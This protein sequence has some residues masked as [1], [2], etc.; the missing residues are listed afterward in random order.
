MSYEYV[1]LASLVVLVGAA[2]QSTAGFGFS[3]IAGP[4][5]FAIEPA[6]V[7]GPVLVALLALTAL[8]S[9]RDGSF[10][11]RIGLRWAL[12]G[13]LPGT[14][15]GVALLQALSTRTLGLLSGAI[16]L[17]SVAL[18]VSPIAIKRSAGPVTFAGFLSGMSETTSSIGGPPVAL[19]YRRDAPGVLRG[20]MSL[21]FL[22]GV[23][24]SLV[25]LAAVGNFGE[26][27]ASAS[28]ALLPGTVAGFLLSKP[29]TSVFDRHAASVVLVLS[30]A[31]GLAVIGQQLV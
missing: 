6:L 17:V 5:L 26:E 29:L 22:V 10:R 14:V 7:P 3:L 8:S 13:R 9:V 15:A 16:V 18:T 19:L 1:L 31:C 30:T 23:S 2:L 4:A 21:F 27:E 24:L 11:D 20:T 25:A 28:L 12:V